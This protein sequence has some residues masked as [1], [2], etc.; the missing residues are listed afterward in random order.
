MLLNANCILCPDTYSAYGATLIE[1]SLIEVGLPGSAKIDSQADAAQGTVEMWLINKVN[2]VNFNFWIHA[3]SVAPKILEAL[4]IAETYMEKTEN[5]TGK[6]RSLQMCWIHKRA[7][8]LW[9]W[10][11]IWGGRDILYQTLCLLQGYIIQKSEKKASVT[12]GKPCE[13]LFT[14]V[15]DCCLCVSRKKFAVSVYDIWFVMS[16]F[17]YDEFHPFLFAQHAKSPYLEFD[18]FDKVHGFMMLYLGMDLIMGIPF[19]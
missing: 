17:R 11:V 12:P 15:S 7:C 14:Y 13:E 16:A 1:H 10:K 9:C 5:F 19:P 3:F 2:K 8:I 4:K 18:N 6:V